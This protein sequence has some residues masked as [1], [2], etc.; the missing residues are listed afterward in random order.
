M[1]LARVSACVWGED[2]WLMGHSGV[3]LA[4][5]MRVGYVTVDMLVP[6][7]DSPK[8]RRQH[9]AAE[10]LQT[11]QAKMADSGGGGGEAGGAADAGDEAAVAPAVTVTEKKKKLP[12]YLHP[13]WL[14]VALLVL[15][16]G[17]VALVTLR[18]PA[19]LVSCD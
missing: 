6:A 7:P 8:V 10:I 9:A 5:V 19:A 16:A 1:V 3:F 13:V 2:Y 14:L 4:M 11:L 12:L 18:A 15:F 17:E